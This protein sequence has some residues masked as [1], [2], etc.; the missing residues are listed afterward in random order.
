MFDFLYYCLYRVF[1][2]IKRVGEKDENLASLFYSILLYTNTITVLLFLKFIIP[3][4]IFSADL[5]SILLKVFFVAVFIF[6]YYACR[7]YF[8]KKEHWKRIVNYY[9]TKYEN[10]KTLIVLISIVYTLLSFFAFIT[11]A[12]LLGKIK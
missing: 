4:G 6:V 7:F 9:T 11:I 5:L 2:L 3:H 8:L 1:S 10:Q 12:S